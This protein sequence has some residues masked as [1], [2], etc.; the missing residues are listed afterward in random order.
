VQAGS[1]RA[2]TKEIEPAVLE[3]GKERKASNS[4]VLLP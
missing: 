2:V 1:K 3:I 4:D